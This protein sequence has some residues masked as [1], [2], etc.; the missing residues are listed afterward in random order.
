VDHTLPL[1]IKRE[2]FLSHIWRRHLRRAKSDDPPRTRR[3]VL[4]FSISIRRSPASPL[5]QGGSRN[6]EKGQM[7][8]PSSAP[9]VLQTHSRCQCVTVRAVKRANALVWN[10]E[11]TFCVRWKNADQLAVA[12]VDSILVGQYIDT[13]SRL[14]V[15]HQEQVASCS[16]SSA[17]PGCMPPRGLD[18]RSSR[19][20]AW[21]REGGRERSERGASKCATIDYEDGRGEE[22]R[23]L[24]VSRPPTSE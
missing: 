23:F 15:N 16:P 12:E 2:C 6:F 8:S 13:Q 11:P 17:R 10:L 5:R 20:R 4:P 21:C 22:I 7:S 9:L 18:P 3:L 24:W 19:A 14:I 1:L